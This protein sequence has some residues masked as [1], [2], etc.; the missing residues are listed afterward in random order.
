MKIPSWEMRVRSRRIAVAAIQRSPIV[1]SVTESMTGLTA[2]QAQLRAGGDHLV[3]GLADAELAHPAAQPPT[4]QLAPARL[5]GAVAEL[6]DGREGE[7]DRL[8]TDDEPVAVSELVGSVVVQP[9]DH[10]GVDDDARSAGVAHASASAPWNAFH[11]SSVTFSTT[12]WSRGGSGRA[13]MS[14][15]TG[16]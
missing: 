13:R 7:H 8:P 6:D 15:S 10:H 11:S 3:V 12:R 14:A 9:T 1:N 16:G 2:P 5:K 4:S